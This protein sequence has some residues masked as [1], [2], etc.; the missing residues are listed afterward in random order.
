MYLDGIIRI[1]VD[2]INCSDLKFRRFLEFFRM[3]GN[4]ALRHEGSKL[5]EI[6]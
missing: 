5:V 3:V 6:I 4:T 1:R 2:Q